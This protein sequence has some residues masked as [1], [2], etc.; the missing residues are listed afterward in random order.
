MIKFILLDENDNF[1]GS[2]SQKEKINPSFYENIEP[3]VDVPPLAYQELLDSFDRGLDVLYPYNDGEDFIIYNAS[4][5]LCEFINHKNQDFLRGRLFGKMFPILKKINYFEKLKEVYRTGKKETIKLF[6]YEDDVL[7][8]SYTKIFLKVKNYVIVSIKEETD[9]NINIISSSEQD[10]FYNTHQPMCTI[11]DL[12]FVRVN[13]AFSKLTGFSIEELIGADFNITK[14]YNPD[15]KDITEIYGELLSH[16]KFFYQNILRL[17]SKNGKQFWIKDLCIPIVYKN[18]P[19]IQV[20]FIDISKSKEYQLKNERLY[21]ALNM[22]QRQ[23]KIAYVSWDEIDGFEW[24]DEIFN[25]LE[26]EYREIHPHYDLFKKHIISEDY[27]RVINLRNTAKNNK[28]SYTAITK[29]KTV[30]GKLKDV[31]AHS[32]F[33]FD[34]ERQ[35][36]IAAGYIQDISDSVAYENKLKDNLYEKEILLKEIHHRVKNNLQIILSLLSLDQRYNPENFGK[37]LDSISNRITSMAIIH[38]NLYKSDNLA[39]VKVS[40]Y[41]NSEIESLMDFYDMEGIEFIADLDKDLEFKIDII[42]PFG[43]I[44]N[45]IVT[46]AVKYAFPTGKGKLFVSIHEDE[47]DMIILKISDDGIGLPDQFNVDNLDSLG[48]IIVNSLT[49]QL[50]GKLKVDGS[51]GTSYEI[52]FKNPNKT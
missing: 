8:A 5:H 4:Y 36:I 42:T 14:P 15:K 25:I 30:N 47:N 9:F 43:L 24:T 33:S 31:K 12:K 40:D 38:E 51:D 20:T 13:L 46:N 3:L 2:T 39:H 6:Y 17:T 7:K 32:T 16:K 21:N 41:I 45:E 22:V 19:A 10:L 23:T 28:S 27:E 29:L 48:L 34:E 18:K 11:Q 44:I 52:R 37:V 50:D 35:C 1:I 49:I 26:L